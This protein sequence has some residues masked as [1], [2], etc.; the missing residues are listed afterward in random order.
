MWT[1]LP[2]STAYCEPYLLI[3]TEKCID[4]YNVLSGI[5]I[6]TF[7]ISN[8]YPL[9]FDG[10]ISLSHD[11]EFEKNHS[12]LIYIS[13]Q[14]SSTSSLNILEKT[15]TKSPSPRE[16]FSLSS[17][18]NSSKPTQS[19][20]DISISQPTAFRHIEH[21]GVDDGMT[22]LS[23]STTKS[24][25]GGRTS[26]MKPYLSQFSSEDRTSM[27]NSFGQT[28]DPSSPLTPSLP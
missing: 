3:Y 19:S 21:L 1:S 28:P 16:G 10:L 12:K 24:Q 13:Q 2:N 23:R 25:N 27:D 22:I 15:S 17:L 18:F 26:M 4:I 20:L 6:Q 8:T 11:L 9:T 7:P 14:N 5:W